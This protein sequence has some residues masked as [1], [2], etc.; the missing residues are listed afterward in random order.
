MKRYSWIAIAAVLAACASAPKTPEN[1]ETITETTKRDGSVVKQTVRS[2]YA[3]QTNAVLALQAQQK[4]IFEMEALEGQVI[5]LKGVKRLAVYAPSAN[6]NQGAT[7]AAPQREIS[8]WEKALMVGDKIFERGLQVMGL[9]YNKQGM[10]AQVLANRDVQLGQQRSNVELV[11]A[12]GSRNAQIAGLI[13][14]PAGTS[15]T[16]NLDSSFLTLGDYSPLTHS[17]N[18]PVRTCTGG[19]GAGSGA[20]SSSTTGAGA[21]SGSGGAG[22]P[23]TC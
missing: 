7:I 22:G 17:S 15:T 16:F 19:G 20:G 2:G 13:Q 9:V 6:A 21:P 23:A 1:G 18:N 5:E 8:G 12:V 14:A 10:I 4:P 3:L 11:D